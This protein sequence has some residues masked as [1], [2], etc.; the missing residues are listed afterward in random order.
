MSKSHLN[1]IHHNHRFQSSSFQSPDD[2]A[3]RYKLLEKLGHGNFGIVFKAL[4]Q[5][6]GEIVAIKEI[7]LENNDDD[8]M[9]IQ[10]EI[11]HLADCDCQYIVKYYGSFVRG[12]KLW[13]IMEFLS[14][15]S[16]LDLLKPGPFPEIAIQTVM[17]ELLLGLNYVHTQK[18]I[19]RDIKSANIL[20]SSTGKV[21]LADFGVA[22]QLST[23]KSKRHTFVGTPFWMAP[24]VIKQSSYNEKADIWSLG[25]TAIELAKGKPPLSEYHPLR[26]LFL[27]PKAKSPTLEDNL[28][29]DRLALYSDE[30]KNFINLCLLKDVHKR[31]TAIQLLNHPFIRKPTNNHHLKKSITDFIGHKRLSNQSP[32][33]INSN[34]FKGS[35]SLVDLIERHSVWKSKKNLNKS[36]PSKNHDLTIKSKK[37]S[38]HSV[39]KTTKTSN[40]NDT[41]ISEWKYDNTLNPVEVYENIINNADNE[42]V[43][44]Q[45]QQFEGNSTQILQNTSQ[46]SDGEADQDELEEAQKA[47]SASPLRTTLGVPAGCNETDFFENEIN[48]TSKSQSPSDHI[49]NVHQ[50]F[51]FENQSVPSSPTLEIQNISK[52]S[53]PFSNSNSIHSSNPF[54]QPQSEIL[55]GIPTLR[56]SNS[57]NVR[58]LTTQLA[59][60][61]IDEKEKSNKLVETLIL[62]D[63]LNSF[64]LNHSTKDI[65]FGKQILQLVLLPLLDQAIKNHPKDLQ[66]EALQT[67]KTG[68]MSLIGNNVVLSGQLMINFIN[69]L[70]NNDLL[71]QNLNGS[72]NDT[73]DNYSEK[74]FTDSIESPCSIIDRFQA[75][76]ESAVKNNAHDEASEDSQEDFLSNPA[77]GPSF[78]KRFVTSNQRLKRSRVS[79]D[80]IS[81]STNGD[82]ASSDGQDSSH[83][84]DKQG[85]RSVISQMLY[86]RWL[87][88]IKKGTS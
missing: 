77:L 62:K 30:F 17:H 3:R 27:I 71:K 46:D 76:I 5:V 60:I 22:T 45:I 36:P 58:S 25:I 81:L 24:E 42:L 63:S 47:M 61:S 53:K 59:Q 80:Q 69:Q 55:E 18:K 34:S 85:P 72:K 16:C 26:V 64:N 2:L 44:H 51:N 20:V 78:S 28:P 57:K 66:S 67:I 88:N 70:E 74:K 9:E 83:D 73:S 68:F 54:N 14:G 79:T 21:K 1:Q 23:H 7:D 19:H 12:Y 6:T 87:S 84:N 40:P 50:N 48:F 39:Y 86:S 37:S 35:G 75:P 65:E 52:S 43:E 4:D 29:S 15:G 31:P 49:Q 38:L 32:S 82:L 11:S 10:Q 33:I 56:P 13:I 41:I 8:I